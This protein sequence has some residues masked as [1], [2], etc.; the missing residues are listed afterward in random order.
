M[1]DSGVILLG[2]IRCE[3]LL[4]V[5]VLGIFLTDEE[6]KTKDETGGWCVGYKHSLKL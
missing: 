4:G 2:E 3:S 6:I 5:N 1:H